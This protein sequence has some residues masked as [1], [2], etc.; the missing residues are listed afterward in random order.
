MTK[1]D[2]WQ[3]SSALLLLCL[4]I[5]ACAQVF[6]TLAVAP[7]VPF[8]M[9]LTQGQDGR[10]YGTTASGGASNYGTVFAITT[11][12]TLTTL[13]SFCSLANCADGAGPQ[14]ALLLGVDGNFYGTTL[15]GGAVNSYCPT[16]CGTIFSVSSGGVLRT[17]YS[18]CTHTPC[19]DGPCNWQSHMSRRSCSRD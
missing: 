16:G 19:V 12:G 4:A 10:L 9:T 11:E 15:Y 14:G 5:P 7:G 3:M 6:T 13:Y 18:F 8:L 1:L 17:V 2:G